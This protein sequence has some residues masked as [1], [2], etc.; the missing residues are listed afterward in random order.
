VKKAL[1]MLGRSTT[2]DNYSSFRSGQPVLFPRVTPFG[3]GVPVAAQN[4][5]CP[6]DGGA[7]VARKFAL[8]A[9]RQPVFDI[10]H[11]PK[12]CAKSRVCAAF[13]NWTRTGESTIPAI[14]WGSEPPPRLS[15]EHDVVAGEK[16]TRGVSNERTE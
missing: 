4:Q 1:I 8:T 7:E 15:R 12:N 3:G 9:L 10:V 2:F 6:A 13:C 5:P 11:S 14:P 16:L